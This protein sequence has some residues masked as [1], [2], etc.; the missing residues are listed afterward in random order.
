MATTSTEL[1]PEQ[2]EITNVMR[3]SSYDRVSSGIVAALIMIGFFVTLMFLIWLMTV[4]VFKQTAVPVELL[5]YGGGV[6]TPEGVA[7]DLEE[8]GIEELAEL[9]EPALAVTLEAVTD[10]VSS[11][12]ASLTSIDSSATKTG[13]G[14]G[15]GDAREKGPGGEGDPNIKPPWERWEIRYNATSVASYAKQLD[16]YKF[17]FGVIGGGFEHIDYVFNLAKAKPD[18]RKGKRDDEERW[19]FVYK[20]GQ[21]AQFDRQIAAKA[22]VPT[23]RRHVL[24]FVNKDTEMMMLR[25]EVEAAQKEGVTNPRE[26]DK[27]VFESQSDGSGFKFVVVD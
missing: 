5:N 16:F 1:R 18:K 12:M 26:F 25:L 13:K 9:E 11:Q 14:S 17:E 27:T 8:P 22:G 20:E 6:D 10:L 21:L 19:Y 7:E 15:L 24:Q 23:T 3:T 2:R 4:L